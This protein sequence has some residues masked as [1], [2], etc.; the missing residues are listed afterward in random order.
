MKKSLKSRKQPKVEPRIINFTSTHWGH[1]LSVG[2]TNEKKGILQGFCWVTPGPRV[3]DLVKYRTRYGVNIAEVTE[4]TWLGNVDDMYRITIK[5]TERI[6]GP[7][8][9]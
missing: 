7:E 4:S 9:F 5:V 3:G 6:P 8:A 1:N 2:V